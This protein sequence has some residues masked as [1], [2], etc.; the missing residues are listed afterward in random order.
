MAVHLRLRRMGKKKQP[1]Y[2]IVA[3]DSRVARDGK[4]LDNL[5]TYNP[6]T[7]PPAVQIDSARVFHWLSHGAKPS[8]TVRSLLRRQ[9]ILMRWHLQKRGMD[10]AQIGEEMKKWE[11]LQSERHKRLE[12]LREQKKQQRK[13]QKETLETP[14]E[15]GENTATTDSASE[16]VPASA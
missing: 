5:G 11:A 7:E 14:T 8:D 9:G 12:A 10:E 15:A 3:I 4:Y 13:S 6:R 2:R 16:A 1:F